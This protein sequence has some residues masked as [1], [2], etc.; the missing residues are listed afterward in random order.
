MDGTTSHKA[1]SIEDVAVIAYADCTCGNTLAVNATKMDPLIKE[2][3]MDWA[4]TQA[5]MEG[6][7][8]PEVLTNLITE[9]RSDILKKETVLSF[10]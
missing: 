9:I 3:L 7:S 6:I 8:A 2:Q 10:K 1:E 5:E 4:E